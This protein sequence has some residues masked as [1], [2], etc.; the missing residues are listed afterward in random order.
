M[1]VSVLGPLMFGSSQLGLE[2]TEA[3]LSIKVGFQIR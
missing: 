2:L 1:L 3:V